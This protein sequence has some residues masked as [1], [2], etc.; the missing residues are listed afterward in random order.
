MNQPE[1]TRRLSILWNAFV[2]NGLTF[3]GGGNTSIR[4]SSSLNYGK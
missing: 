3:L 1:I 2:K 4:S